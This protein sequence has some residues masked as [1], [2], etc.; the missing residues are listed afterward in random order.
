MLFKSLEFQNVDKCLEK[1]L[2]EIMTTVCFR[3]V[4]LFI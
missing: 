2:I 4:D 3:S 1:K